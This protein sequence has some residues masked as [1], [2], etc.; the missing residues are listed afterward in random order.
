MRSVCTRDF[1]LW[2]WHLRIG[3]SESPGWGNG[4]ER[5]EKTQGRTPGISVS[6]AVVQ[7]PELRAHSGAGHISPLPAL[8]PPKGP[9]HS[10][11]V[12]FRLS[13]GQLFALG[14]LLGIAPSTPF[15]Y[16]ET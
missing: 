3:G 4:R 12:P 14:S 8:F 11:F 1:H 5:H 15:G 13:R 10:F 6:D 2:A 16:G 7:S 9:Y